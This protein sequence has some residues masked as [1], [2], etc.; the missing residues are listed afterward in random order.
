VQLPQPHQ[1]VHPAAR[2]QVVLGQPL[3]RHLFEGGPERLQLHPLHRQ[4]R[5]VLVPTEPRQVPGAGLQRVIQVAR[6][7]D[8]TRP[9]P[10]PAP[11]TARTPCGPTAAPPPRPPPWTRG[12][13][14]TP[15]PPAPPT[16]PR[17]SPDTS[18]SA[19]TPG[20]RPA[21]SSSSPCRTR[22]RLAPVSGTTSAMV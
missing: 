8:A 17:P 2:H 3:Q 9:H 14:R 18:F 13:S 6:L 5:R 16:P 10:Q 4:P 20:R 15:P 11:P 12:P 21:V 19:A 1:R 22:I 7:H